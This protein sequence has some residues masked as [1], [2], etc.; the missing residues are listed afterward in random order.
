MIREYI[1][2]LL[3]AAISPNNNIA[4]FRSQRAYTLYDVNKTMLAI[5]DALDETEAQAIKSMRTKSVREAE[6]VVLRNLMS[7]ANLIL[8]YMGIGIK[9]GNYYDAALVK[10]SSAVKGYGPLLY[11]IVM[12][13]ENGL[14]PDRDQVSS[15][16]RNVWNYYFNKRPDVEHKF[17]D[18]KS[19]PET[20]PEIDDGEIY[21]APRDDGRYVNDKNNPLNYAYFL[22]NP[23]DTKKMVLLHEACQK[24]AKGLGLSAKEFDNLVKFCSADFV[25]AKLKA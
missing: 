20:P 5:Q 18:D 9:P 22:K 7:E 14:V 4:L 13:H 1:K 15:Q 6:F 17:L 25:A 21:P 19:N 11:D 16:A 24:R 2:L 23:V 12:W 3:E 10:V 8:G